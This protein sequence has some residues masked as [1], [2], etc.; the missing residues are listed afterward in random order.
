MYNDRNIT[1]LILNFRI[2]NRHNYIYLNN[3]KCGCTT[4]KSLLYENERFHET[5]MVDEVGLPP[6][7]ANTPFENTLESI[8]ADKRYFYFSMVR[9]PYTRVLSGYLNKIENTTARNRV[10]SEF[11]KRYNLSSDARVTFDQFVD[12]ICATKPSGL[13][14]HWRPQHLILG[15]S[16]LPP[17]YV[18]YLE[19]FSID[20]PE[21]LNVIF[22]NAQLSNRVSKN[23]KNAREKLKH[24]FN[25]EIEGKIR[26]Y[27][28]KDFRVLGYSDRLSEV[29]FIEPS[30][31][32]RRNLNKR[33]EFRRHQLDKWRKQIPEKF[34]TRSE[35]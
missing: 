17:S 10:K 24:Y 33:T 30:H 22:P 8:V 29:E 13:N 9:N 27:F 16:I 5:G 32:N 6:E 19:R 1:R 23:A 2:S 12:L 20:M 3:R 15:Y 31:I 21:I 28:A 34:R 18:G 35:E 7:I 14:L 25:R 11:L 4:I 26:D